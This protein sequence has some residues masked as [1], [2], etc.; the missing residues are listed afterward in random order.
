MIN[1]ETTI[2]A[3]IMHRVNVPFHL[4]YSNFAC[5]AVILLRMRCPEK[6]RERPL[7]PFGHSFAGD[8]ANLL[9][10]QQ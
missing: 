1:V 4:Q 9:S 7:G 3:T 5:G 6:R 8:T 10:V 2:A